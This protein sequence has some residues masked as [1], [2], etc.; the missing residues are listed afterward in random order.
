MSNFTF[1]E[2]TLIRHYSD[3]SRT[4]TVQALLNMRRYLEPDE[5]ALQ[6]LADSAIH[7]LQQ[8]SDKEFENMALEDIEVFP[9]TLL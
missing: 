4:G 8:I 3:G 7:G 9:S 1:E 2:R 5:Q 6:Y